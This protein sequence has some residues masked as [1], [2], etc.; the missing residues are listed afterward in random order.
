MK[1]LNNKQWLAIIAGLAT[2]ILISLYWLKEQGWIIIPEIESVR[3]YQQIDYAFGSPE[4]FHLPRPYSRFWDIVILP[5]FVGI[6]IH[7][8]RH[9]LTEA[10]PWILGLTMLI[11]LI[12][13][14]CFGSGILSIYAGALFTA[15]CGLV[16]GD[17]TA[18]LMSLTLGL[19]VGLAAFG[20][21]FGLI[22]SG[23]SY[24]AFLGISYVVK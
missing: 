7:S 2:L 18:V 17:W 16:F 23:L 11:I 20:L 10:N 24:L 21:L 14:Y 6:I 3:M 15:V 12:L 19:L 5:F 4:F 13:A 22:I 1:L 8:G 9:T